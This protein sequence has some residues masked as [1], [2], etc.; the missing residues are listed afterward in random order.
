M[1]DVEDLALPPPGDPGP[2][3]LFAGSV[4]ERGALT[5]HALRLTV[6][7][8]DFFE[9][10]RTWTAEYADASA[11]TDDFIAVAEEVS[12]QDLDALFQTWL[13]EEELPDLPG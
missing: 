11:T 1:N 13:Y 3:Q 8:E 7:D 5:V 6:G 4:Y 2:D 12:G 10:L 9:I